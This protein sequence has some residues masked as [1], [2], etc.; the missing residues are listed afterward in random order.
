MTIKMSIGKLT[1]TYSIEQIIAR[2]PLEF[3]ELLPIEVPHILAIQK[4]PFHH[5]D[6]FDRLLIAQTEAEAL[7]ITSNETLFDQNAVKGIW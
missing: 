4:L 1:L 2:L 3:I 5:K 6:P 7:T